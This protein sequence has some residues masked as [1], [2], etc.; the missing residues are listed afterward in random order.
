MCRNLTALYWLWHSDKETRVM[1]NDLTVSL[2]LW[3]S[4]VSAAPCL[5]SF[6]GCDGKAMNMITNPQCVGVQRR[7]AQHNWWAM[8]LCKVVWFKGKINCGDLKPH[9]NKWHLTAKSWGQEAPLEE[10]FCSLAP[11]GKS[12]SS[13]VSLLG[14]SC[15]GDNRSACRGELV[16]LGSTTGMPAGCPLW[17]LH[18][19]RAVLPATCVGQ[20]LPEKYPCYDID[21]S[22]TFPKLQS[23]TI[24]QY[25][26]HDGWLV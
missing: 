25:L 19:N 24:G 13:W 16:S 17:K 8:T 4:K 3:I 20:Y 11:N 10:T 5:S 14:P 23:E 21:Q 22:V 2:N 9:A 18:P 15:L 7:P 1:K 6:N 26:L 12:R